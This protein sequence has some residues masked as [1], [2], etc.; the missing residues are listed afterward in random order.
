MAEQ[1]SDKR[2]NMNSET[3]NENSN[4]QQDDQNDNASSELGLHF[5]N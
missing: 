2:E 5:Y 4:V 1:N 3:S